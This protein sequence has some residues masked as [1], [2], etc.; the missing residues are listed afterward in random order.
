MAAVVNTLII[1]TVKEP[2]RKINLVVL[3]HSET[4]ALNR[5]GEML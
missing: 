3:M 4:L 5:N 2:T 1:Y